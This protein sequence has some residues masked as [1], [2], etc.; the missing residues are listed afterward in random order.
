MIERMG[1]RIRSE[2]VA[3]II[4]MRKKNGDET[5]KPVIIEFKSEYDK[6][7]VMRNKAELRETEEYKS[8]FRTGFVDRGKGEKRRERIQEWKA[9]WVMRGEKIRVGRR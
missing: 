2:D 1:V 8:F 9:E 3:D 5:V 7:M 6:W 4:R